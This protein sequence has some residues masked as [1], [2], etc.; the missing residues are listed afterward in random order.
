MAVLT[1][2]QYADRKTEKRIELGMAG[3]NPAVSRRVVKVR[4][5]KTTYVLFHN[6]HFDRTYVDVLEIGGEKIKRV[7]V[8]GICRT[9]NPNLRQFLIG[10]G[11]VLFTE[12]K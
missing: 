10:V 7:V 1:A 9:T 12:E 5:P 8:N 2:K 11:W 4:E 6:E 3:Q